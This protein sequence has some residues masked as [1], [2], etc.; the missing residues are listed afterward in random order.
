MMIVRNWLVKIANMSRTGSAPLMFQTA[1][2]RR[3]ENT[4]I[5]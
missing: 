2:P 4:V 1:V 5:A 3:N